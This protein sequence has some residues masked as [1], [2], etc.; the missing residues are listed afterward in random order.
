MKMLG[1]GP[2]YHDIMLIFD[3]AM[4]YNNPGDWIHNDA[5]QFKRTVGREK[6]KIKKKWKALLRKQKPNK[7][8]NCHPRILIRRN[9]PKRKAFMS[10]KTRMKNTNTMKMMITMI[11]MII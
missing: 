9:N 7:E 8:C 11:I 1:Q 3:N 5:L 2:I 10:T 4:T 6:K